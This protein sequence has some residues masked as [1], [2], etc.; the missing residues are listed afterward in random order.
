MCA[1]LCD[2]CRHPVAIFFHL[3]F[4][5]SA[6]VLYLVA[7]FVMQ[8][9]T[10]GEMGVMI[11]IILLL[12]VDFWTVKNITGRILAGLRW[13]NKVEEDGTS[14]WVFEWR[15]VI[16][17]KYSGAVI[18]SRGRKERVWPCK[19]RAVME[20]RSSAFDMPVMLPPPPPPPPLIC[21][22]TRMCPLQRRTYSGL[23]CSSVLFCGWYSSSRPSSSSIL[24]GWWVVG[25]GNVKLGILM[26]V[27]LYDQLLLLTSSTL[28]LCSETVS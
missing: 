21:R 2:S 27:T 11:S 23:A 5:V 13:W 15:K 14:T 4:R 25:G 12:A 6:L 22:I 20:D 16:A 24:H 17:E 10:V 1:M 18:V 9:S 19:T 7:H 3:A 8:M 28:S 26:C